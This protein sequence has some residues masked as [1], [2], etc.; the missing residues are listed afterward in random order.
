MSTFT[1]QSKSEFEAERTGKD[2][3]YVSGTP[4]CIL[5]TFKKYTLV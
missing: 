4:I 1:E 5:I 2:A 3:S